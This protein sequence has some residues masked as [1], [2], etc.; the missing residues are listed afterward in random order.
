[1]P[2]RCRGKCELQVTKIV[3]DP[4]QPE[5]VG[6]PPVGPNFPFDGYPHKAD[7]NASIAA[8]LANIRAWAAPYATTQCAQHPPEPPGVFVMPCICRR[9][10]AEPTAAEWAAMPTLTRE[11]RHKF[12]SKNNKW[13]S[14]VVVEYKVAY[15]AGACEEPPGVIFYAAAATFDDGHGLVVTSADGEPLDAALL[16]KIKGVLG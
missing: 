16:S 15:V 9:T 2:R 7:S 13:E 5:V 10:G 3:N 8:L 4:P 11:F 6:D 1:M 12:A 14:K